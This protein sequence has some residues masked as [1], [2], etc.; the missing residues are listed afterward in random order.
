MRDILDTIQLLTESTGLA[1]R[2]P[3]A[4]FK[5]ENDDIAT[6]VDIQFYPEDGGKY[7]PEELDQILEQLPENVYWQNQRSGRT[8]G[9]GLATFSTDQGEFTVGR[10]LEQV[11][12]AFT[13]NYIPNSFSAVESNWKYGGAAAVKAESFLTPQDLLTDKSDLTIP[14]IMKQLAISMGTDNPL[15]AVAHAVAIGQGLPIKFPAPEGI[16]FTAFRDYFCEILQPIAL[17]KGSYE[18]N[19][20]EAAERFLGGTFEGTLISFG[21]S[22]TAGLSDSIMT[23]GDG[24]SVKVSSKGKKGATASAKNLVDSVEELQATKEGRKILAKYSDTIDMLRDMQAYGQA[25]SPLMLG[26]RFGIINNK[27]MEVIKELK[28][29]GPI[30]MKKIDSLNLTPKLKKLAIERNTDNPDNVNLYYHLIAAVAHKVADAVNTKTDFSKAATEILNNGALVQ[31]YTIAKQGKA[32]WVL[33]RFDTVYPGTTIKGV[34]LDASKT[35]YSTGINGNFTFK[36]DKGKGLP[37]DEEVTT[38]KKVSTQD[39]D[40]DFMAGAEELAGGKSKARPKND[41]GGV[42]TK[43]KK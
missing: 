24:R 38:S 4:V 18:G 15:Y 12:P 39:L 13:D 19:A 41:G 43:R 17:Q 16:S 5:N 11:K 2:K 33:E 9:F 26:V 30:N 27:D 28:Q 1:G 8:G 14:A 40:A 21:Q 22:K 25:G 29:F 3:G 34:F 37:K 7:T 35:H 23:T 31:V 42:R 36:I 6:F 20:G 32:E 10:Y